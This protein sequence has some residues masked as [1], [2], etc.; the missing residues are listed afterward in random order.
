[1]DPLPV[2]PQ[3]RYQD[4]AAMIDHVLLEPRLTSRQVLDGLET[5]KQCGAAA[6]LVRPGD[7]EAAVRALE[8]SGVKPG[9]VCGFPHGSQNTAT[10][11]YEARDLLRRGAR[12]IDLVIAVSRLL[13]REFQ[14]VQT[15]L[16][17]IVEACHKEGAALGVILE[18]AYLTG[19]LKIIACRSAE[20]AEA[21]F[22]VTSTGFAPSGFTADDARLMRQYL[23]ESIGVK[24][25]GGIETL[26]AVLE[27]HA[28]GCSR[29]ATT[30]TAAILEEWKRR[31][32][33]ATDAAT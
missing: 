1:M 23:P 31:T 15:E 33:A 10:K 16:S 12:Q 30:A 32:D 29:V 21:D 24:A 18:N 20:R 26:D 14:Y 11:A 5:A 17:Q 9:S 3:L 22:V 2:S 8:G 27:A 28:A 6:A 7:I 19:E 25:A 13:S 4:L